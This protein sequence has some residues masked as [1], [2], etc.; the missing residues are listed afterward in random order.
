V[1]EAG[2]QRP[3]ELQDVE[4]VAGTESFGSGLVAEASGAAV[5]GGAAAAEVAD[6]EAAASNNRASFPMREDFSLWSS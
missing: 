4:D 2:A 3:L 5:D 6:G 1:V